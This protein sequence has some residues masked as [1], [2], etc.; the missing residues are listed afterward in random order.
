M[1]SRLSGTFPNSIYIEDAAAAGLRS[2]EH[3]FGFEKV[4]AKLL[5]EPVEITLTRHG[6][7]RRLFAASG[8]SQP[9]RH[10]RHFYQRLRASGMTICPTVVT[11]KI[12]PNVNFPDPKACHG[13]V[14]T[15]HK[16]CSGHLEIA[17]GRTN[18][19]AGFIL[20][21]LGTNGQRDEQGR[22]TA[23]GGD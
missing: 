3:W 9:G 16:T 14:N 21:K 17:L 10:C 8:R 22:G 2:S 11:F 23:D 1:G 5:G 20:A 7:G 4:I 6:I 19:P 15:S 18:R 12:W 13:T